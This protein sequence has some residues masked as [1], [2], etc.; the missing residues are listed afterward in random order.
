M[1]GSM[2][3]NAAIGI[4]KVFVVRIKVTVRWSSHE[5]TRVLCYA[6]SLYSDTGK[7]LFYV[8]VA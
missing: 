3:G 8:V 7:T 5:Y 2:I 6:S 4:G 1:R